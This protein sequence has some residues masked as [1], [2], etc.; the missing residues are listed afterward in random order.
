M[1]DKHQDWTPDEAFWNEA[2]ADMERRLD[3][4]RR[5]AAWLPWLLGLALL[6]GGGALVHYVYPDPGASPVANATEPVPAPVREEPKRSPGI[7]ASAGDTPE[8]NAAPQAP[9]VLLRTRREVSMPAPTPAA[10]V[11]SPRV[12]AVSDGQV[13]SPSAASTATLPFPAPEALPLAL[14]FPPFAPPS[15]PAAAAIDPAPRRAH[16]TLAVGSTIFPGS[17]LPGAFVDAGTR[18]SLGE[19]GFVPLTLRLAYDRR[20]SRPDADSD[21]REA[22]DLNSPIAAPTNNVSLDE[23]LS[24]ARTGRVRTLS[25]ELRAGY[26]RQIT[27]K[28]SLSGGASVAYLLWGKGPLLYLSS[29]GTS[30]YL[31]SSAQ[32]DLA[33]FRNRSQT[34]SGYGYESATT[35]HRWGGRGWL[36]ADY[37]FGR[38]FGARAGLSY[39]VRPLY[40]SEVLRAEPLRIEVGATLR[41]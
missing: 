23:R 19:K 15:R 38:R 26:G 1:P 31:L 7:A 6:L 32:F 29:G 36:Q 3:T 41:F 22:V 12:P 16:G 10:P 25:L 13:R 5:R 2:W 4:R 24:E 20:G 14:N 21:L 11:S 9:P 35:I 18:F 37:R 28:L 30:N 8:N 40:E 17:W 33:D 39:A 27:E 34:Y